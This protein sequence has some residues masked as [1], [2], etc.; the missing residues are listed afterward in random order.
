MRARLTILA[1]L[2][3]VAALTVSATAV[4]TTKEYVLK[5]PKHEHCKSQYV[6]KS[7]TVRRKVHGHLVKVHETVCV[8]SSSSKPPPSS[9]TAKPEECTTLVSGAGPLPETHLYNY[10]VLLGCGKGEF[11]S[12]QVSINRAI[13]AGTIMAKIGSMF[14][15]TC[16]Q[17]SSTSFSC[18]GVSAH[19]PP[20]GAEVRAFF[21]SGQPPCEGG[22]PET[23]TI[24]TAGETFNAKIGEVQGS[25]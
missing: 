12:F 9:T 19:I 3:A 5:H 2:T 18:T 10:Q 1:L 22:S 6:K 13:E 24:T 16:T 20:E 23:A 21:K 17:S 8:R 7:K 25:C 14:T 4:A 15:Y 11:G